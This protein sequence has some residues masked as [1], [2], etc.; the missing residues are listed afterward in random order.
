LTEDSAVDTDDTS[1]EMAADRAETWLEIDV[2]SDVIWLDCEVDRLLTALPM[3]EKAL[4]LTTEALETCDDRPVSEVATE[5][6]APC[7]PPIWL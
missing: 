6:T 5:F 4:E 3:A 7:R 2:D 1:A